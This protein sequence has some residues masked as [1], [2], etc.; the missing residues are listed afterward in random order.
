MKNKD[1]ISKLKNDYPDEEEIER[2]KR[3]MELLEIKNGEDS[4][5]FYL[6]STIN[7]LAFAF[8]KFIK[9]SINHFDI[10]PLYC[11]SLFGYNWPGGLNY[12]GIFLQTF[13][14]KDKILLLKLILE[15]VLAV[16]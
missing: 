16:L 1:F 4:R 10:N 12:T 8:E 9:I 3:I 13:Q 2:T 6:R 5:N 15:G 11:V 7:L 14:D